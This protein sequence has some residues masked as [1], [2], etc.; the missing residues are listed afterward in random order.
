[1]SRPFENP[2]YYGRVRYLVNALRKDLA[3]KM[4]LLAGPRQVGKSTLARGLLSSTGVYL[5]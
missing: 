5:N 4:I 1:M 3:K 2:L